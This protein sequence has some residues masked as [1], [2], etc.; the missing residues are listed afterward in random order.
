MLYVY[1]SHII[2]TTVD[3]QLLNE[4]RIGCCLSLSTATGHHLL[5]CLLL[6]QTQ[7]CAKASTSSL[8][9]SLSILLFLILP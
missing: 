4:C 8:N 3:T 1:F 7:T 6:P 9:C 2:L 5:K